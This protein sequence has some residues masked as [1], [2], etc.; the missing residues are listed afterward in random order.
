MGGR[1]APLRSRAHGTCKAT[2]LTRGHL[3]ALL[4]LPAL[5]LI[6]TGCG[7]SAAAQPSHPMPGISTP[8]ATSA[9]PTAI[10][11]TTTPASTDTPRRLVI[12]AIHIDTLIEPVGITNQG[13]MDTPRQDPWNHVGWYSAGHLPG[14]RG[15]AVIDGHLDR[16]GGAPAVFW[17]LNQ[18]RIGDE[19]IVILASGK[20]LHFRV[21]NLAFYAPGHAP[22]Q[23]IFA[24]TSGHYLNLIT[25]AGAWIPTQHQTTQRLVVYASLS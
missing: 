18:L 6:L 25:C 15:S 7:E 19:I 1:L 9:L 3:L 23:D 13:D 11:A 14:E 24:N 4:C 2:P 17:S 16:P 22:L 12:P 20:T 21:L 8:T 5:L 10:A